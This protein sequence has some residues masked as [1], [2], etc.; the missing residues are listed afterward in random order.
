MG[1]SG[2][3]IFITGLNWPSKKTGWQSWQRWQRWWWWW[4]CANTINTVLHWLYAMI[5]IFCLQQLISGFCCQV[6]D[7]C[8][9]LGYYAARSSN[10]RLSSW[11]SRPLNKGPIGWPKISITNYHHML[12]ISPEDPRTHFTYKFAFS[13]LKGICCTTVLFSCNLKIYEIYTLYN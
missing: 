1:G 6:D 5:K 12:H 4:W 13:A 3:E 9:L 2:I 8:D 10:P 11:I 7:I